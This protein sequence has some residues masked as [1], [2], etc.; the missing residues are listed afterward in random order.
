MKKIGSIWD[1]PKPGLDP[2][3]WDEE[4]KLLENHKRLI[5]SH[6]YGT[7]LGFGYKHFDKWIKDIYVTGSLTTYQ[8]NKWSDL[9]V[10]IVIDPE[11]FKEYEG[12]EKVSDEALIDYLNTDVRHFLN[13]KAQ[14]KLEGT[15]HPVEYWFEL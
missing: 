8:Y 6:L 14:V 10:H 13:V 1:Y 2:A 5:L 15:E 11:L 12:V 4:G 9:D 7:L 3:V